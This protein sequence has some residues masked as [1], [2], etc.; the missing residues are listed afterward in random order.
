[1]SQ[2]GFAL[3]AYNFILF[4]WKTN[5]GHILI[6]LYIDD[7]II[8]NDIYIY[9]IERRALLIFHKKIFEVANHNF[10]INIQLHK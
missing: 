7:M 4:V 2:F 8:I 9:I 6:L 1:M 10:L 5:K 3:N